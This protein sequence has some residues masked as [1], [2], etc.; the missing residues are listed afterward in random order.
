[1]SIASELTALNG[2]ILDAYGEVSGKG[3]TVPAN[4]NMANLASAIAS[5]SGGGGGDPNIASGQLILPSGWSSGTDLTIQHG[6]SGEPTLF[7]LYYNCFLFGGMRLFLY[8]NHVSGDAE[9]GYQKAALSWNG[10]PAS[11]TNGNS[12][13]S[14]VNYVTS[15]LTEIKISGSLASVIGSNYIN[16]YKAYWWAMRDA[17][18]NDFS[19][20]I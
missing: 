7:F 1:M 18:G 4:K 19:A 20:I 17:S 9:S 3:G 10:A 15:N 16:N 5:I 11:I 8:H 6:L 12:L 13:A 14:G 2:Y